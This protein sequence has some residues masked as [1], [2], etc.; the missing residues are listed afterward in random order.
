[1]K[2]IC[3]R[4]NQIVDDSI[5]CSSCGKLLNSQISEKKDVAENYRYKEIKITTC[6]IKSE[7]KYKDLLKNKYKFIKEPFYIEEDKEEIYFYFNESEISL[8]KYIENK[9][10][11]YQTIKIIM[12]KLNDIFIHLEEQKLVVDNINLEDFSL[13]DNDLNTL[14]LKR[15]RKFISLENKNINNIKYNYG[16]DLFIPGINEENVSDE[17]DQSSNVYILGSIFM[18]LIFNGFNLTT[19]EEYDYY[20]YNLSLFR[21]DINV[22]FHDFIHKSINIFKE[23]RFKNVKEFKECFDYI[24]NQ[25]NNNI[26]ESLIIEYSAA[27]DVGKGKLKKSIAKLGL[28]TSEIENINEDDFNQDSYYT[29][30]SNN[31]YIF[32]VA[33]GVST[34]DYGNGKEASTILK[35]NIIDAWEEFKEHLKDED[36]IKEFL[37]EVITQTNNEI[38][39]NVKGTIKYKEE[40]KGNSIMASTLVLGIVIENTLYY[41][42]IGDS[43]IFIY[44]EIEGL[45]ILNYEDNHG[46]Y[47]LVKG[48]EWIS[49]RNGNDNDLLIKYIGGGDILNHKVVPKKVPI[50]IS[51]IKL[52]VND[53]LIFCSDGVTDYLNSIAYSNDLWK[54]DEKLKNI[55]I[56][57][58]C[59]SLSKF[60]E[61]VL[62]EANSNGGGDNITII[63]AKIVNSI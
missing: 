19:K 3:L 22:K 2:N 57:N 20:L 63:T 27:T 36:S 62:L 51:K 11:S 16:K 53:I 34:A 13:V 21:K 55:L 47:K 10:I 29:D 26:T 50:S 1:M 38:V 25:E 37:E 41:V 45:N 61:E 6:N 60:N 33:D 42:S 54:Q 59:N 52:Q 5:Y 18:E 35:N 39:N 49:Y 7:I 31:T 56:N 8:K 9:K 17:I 14:Y 24:I 12:N 40:G 15:K 58:K 48:D 32:S 43:K 23:L 30:V 44:N 46:N 4:C 28:T